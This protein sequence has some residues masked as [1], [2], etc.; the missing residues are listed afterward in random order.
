M[1]R[2]RLGESER[3]LPRLRAAAAVVSLLA[4]WLAVA[5]ETAPNG[6]ADDLY[7]RLLPTAERFGPF[8]GD[9]PAAAGFAAGQL[10]GYVFHTQQVVASTGFSGKP[11]D[12]A[13]GLAADLRI[14][15]LEIVEHH[16]PI[17]VIGVSDADL[18]RFVD[19]YRG[20]DIRQ[21]VRVSRG[22]GGTGTVDAV[23][24][25][26]I[27]SVVINDAVLRSARAVAASRGLLGGADLDFESF[28]AVGWRALLDEGSLV[29]LRLAT[30]VVE[31]A[32]ADRGG[33]LYPEGAGPRDPS[34]TFIELIAGLAS[35][36]RVGRNLLGG[37]DFNAAMAPLAP[38]DHII[39]VAARGLY[40]FKG[41]SYRR[42][43]TF[44]RIRLIQG[45]RAFRFRADDHIRVEK[46]RAEGA[47]EMREQ[48]LFVIRG[49]MGF[50]PDRPWRLE[51]LVTGE[52]GSG[53][54][55]Q[56]GY[57]LAYTLPDRY[58]RA[59]AAPAE[60]AEDLPLWRQV[61]ETRLWDV[62]VL[63]IALAALTALFVFQ[64]AVVRRG[65][66]YDRIRVG[67]LL[68]CLVWLGWYAGAQLSVLN[69][70]TF[71]E[72]LRTGFQWEFFLLDPLLFVLWSY[73]AVAMLFLGRGIFCGWLCPF[74]ALQEMANRLARLARVPQLRLPF[75]LN[76]RLW[77][78]KYIIFLGLFALSL[79]AMPAA[80]TGAEVEPFKT[81]IV[82]RFDRPWL[83]A[84]YPIVLLV[85]ALFID[86]FF[87][88]YL[89]PLGAALAIPARLAMFDWLKRRW[90]CGTQ[91]QRCATRC[92]VQA[93][94]PNGRI[95]A[96]E[97]IYCLNCQVNY[98]DDYLCPPLIE[99]RKRHEKYAAQRAAAK[100]SGDTSTTPGATP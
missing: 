25:A 36:A 48:A 27:S 23:A 2:G 79:S 33:R 60:M 84:L 21:P 82:L 87:C 18:D 44:D 16:E 8:E 51:L 58:V 24:G 80:Q 39:F 42:G 68:F 86:R 99:L 53:P 14:A 98:Y 32:M 73:V 35:P 89:C 22:G 17:L 81:A 19:R 88:R 54:P 96:N 67:F 5:A 10:V 92:P 40:S 13:V 15:G 61:W 76:E 93:I 26:T 43:G 49:T 37:L 95:N 12:I 90:H 30:G 78:V 45:D 3:W 52:S 4:P 50:R 47:P 29:R 59:G 34:A 38:G 65:R 64:D 77:P 71:A 63:G 85:A 7:R 72:A 56:V 41:T 46:L 57:D 83:F 55:A 6:G 74:G 1:G 20:H 97:C 9:P 91:C 11:L 28:E 62:A 70:L 100:A 66:L 75:A 31:G 94:H 69:V